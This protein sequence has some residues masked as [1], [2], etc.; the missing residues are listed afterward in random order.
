M[1]GGAWANSNFD[2]QEE[3]AEGHR[4]KLLKDIQDGCDRAIR[5]VY[6]PDEVAKEDKID[7]NDP[8]FAAMKVQK[9]DTDELLEGKA[10][11]EG[12]Q[13]KTKRMEGVDQG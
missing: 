11:V 6:Q 1:V 3:G 8:F 4:P 12:E 10:R 9:L 7:W 5:A 2:P 13:T